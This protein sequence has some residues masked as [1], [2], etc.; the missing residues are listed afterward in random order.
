MKGP[1][2]ATPATGHG[3]PRR[4]AVHALAHNLVRRR[5]GPPGR[6]A[7]TVEAQRADRHLARLPIPADDWPT[8][9]GAA[10]QRA[11]ARVPKACTHLAMVADARETGSVI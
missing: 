5:D 11:Y 9:E 10:R 1:L 8:G 4:A 3:A 6:S 7:G 2:R